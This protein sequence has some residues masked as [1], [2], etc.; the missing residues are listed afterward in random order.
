MK[1]ANGKEFKEGDTVLVPMKVL[2][3][4]TDPGIVLNVVLE[5]VRAAPNELPQHMAVHSSQ[6]GEE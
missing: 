2:K 4:T 3:T 5:P 6:I 1:D